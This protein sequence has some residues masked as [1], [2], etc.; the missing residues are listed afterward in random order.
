MY[1]DESVTPILNPPTQPDVTDSILSIKYQ[2]TPGIF[3]SGSSPNTANNCAFVPAATDE[4]PVD[5]SEQ[6]EE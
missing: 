3:L 4:E 5:E 1:G 2:P 6:L